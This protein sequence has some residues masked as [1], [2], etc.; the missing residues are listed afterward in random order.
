MSYAETNCRRRA[1]FRHSRRI[2]ADRAGV[3]A[4]EFA[5]VALAV[6]TFMFG[7]MEAAR[8]YWDYQIIEEVAIE[9]ARCMGI[10]ASGCAS[11]GAYSSTAANSFIETLAQSRGLSL[12]ATNLSLT[13]P[14]NC[15][16]T[17]GFS[18]VTI[19]YTFTTV[20]PVMLHAFSSIPLS[21]TACYYDTQ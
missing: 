5:L 13:R 18:Q 3:A 15:G 20:S 7:M 8:A 2:M 14:T 1:A 4:V 11:G 16:G 9:G 19:T 21:T 6:L 12:A 17:A 10:L